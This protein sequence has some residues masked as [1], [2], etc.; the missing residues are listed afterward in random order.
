MKKL[1]TS[2]LLIIALGITFI[3]VNE[4]VNDIKIAKIEEEIN[5]LYEDMDFFDE[6]QTEIWE[7]VDRL[8]NKI[9]KVK[10]SK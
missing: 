5:C 10:T 7:Q 9:D 2:L 3:G 6:E 4:I 1:I 8:D